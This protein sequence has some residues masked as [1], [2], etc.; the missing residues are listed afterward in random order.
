MQ[1]QSRHRTSYMRFTV[2]KHLAA[3]W[4]LR[5]KPIC[6]KCN[7]NLPKT[8]EPSWIPS[9]TP[10]ISLC[11]LSPRIPRICTY[12]LHYMLIA[13]LISINVGSNLCFR[14]RSL[15]A[16]RRRSVTAME[17][18]HCSWMPQ[19]DACT[20]LVWILGKSKYLLIGELWLNFML[21][22]FNCLRSRRNHSGLEF[23]TD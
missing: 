6:H 11:W 21:T 16:M 13:H 15:Y 3:I 5:C 8:A 1:V 20:Q 7:L 10:C 23:N 12:S 14:F 9:R 17:W 4:V 2:I 19:M 22:E 18:M